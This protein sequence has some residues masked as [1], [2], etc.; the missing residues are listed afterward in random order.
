M[1]RAEFLSADKASKAHDLL[2]A[3]LTE[4]TFDIA[5]CSL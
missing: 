1:G 2:Q 4:K 5:A 3:A